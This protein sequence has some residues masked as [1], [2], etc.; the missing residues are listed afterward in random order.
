M[1]EA[2]AE[3]AEVEAPAD[4]VAAVPTRHTAEPGIAVPT[5]ATVHAARATVRSCRIRLRATAI[6]AIPV[7]SPL[8]YVA[9]HIVD[10]EFIG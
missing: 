4:G 3:V 1:G 10:A 6:F 5:A 2:Q 7:R 8:P 9:A